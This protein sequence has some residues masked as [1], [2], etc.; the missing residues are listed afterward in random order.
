[1]ENDDIHL[2]WK[3]LESVAKKTGMRE[4]I[5]DGR[6]QNFQKS[7]D[8]GFEEGFKNGFLLGKFKGKLMGEAKQN[9]SELKTHPLLENI[10]RGSCEICKN[11]VW[12]ENV[13]NLLD[14]QRERYNMNNRTL[15]LHSRNTS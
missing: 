13:E 14:L 11:S 9:G 12:E 2:T 10:S 3:K 15:I 1:M 4:G 6:D 8:I 5:S 7:F